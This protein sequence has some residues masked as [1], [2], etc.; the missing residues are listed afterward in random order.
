[1]TESNGILVRLGNVFY[2]LGTGVAVLFILRGILL[3]LESPW[4]SLGPPRTW[5]DRLEDFA[6]NV[7]FAIVAWLIG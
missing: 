4:L 1:M 3:A 2:W 5:G 6:V 7:G